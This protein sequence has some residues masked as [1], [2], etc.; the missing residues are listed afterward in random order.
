[1]KVAEGLSPVDLHLQTVRA[2]SARSPLSLDGRAVLEEGG[3]LPNRQSSQP[4]PQVIKS[5]KG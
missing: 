4:L 3:L 1:M 5:C 2:S